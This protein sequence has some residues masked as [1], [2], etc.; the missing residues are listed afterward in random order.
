MAAI[1]MSASGDLQEVLIGTF[2]KNKL[3]LDTRRKGNT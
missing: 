2:L 3:L 1:L